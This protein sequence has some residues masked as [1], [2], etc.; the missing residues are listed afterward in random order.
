MTSRI[1][2]RQLWV[3]ENI[4]QLPLVY[5]A[6]QVPNRL[7]K[8][9]LTEAIESR[10]K[11]TIAQVTYALMC[12]LRIPHTS[13]II[14]LLGVGLSESNFEEM[15]KWVARELPTVVAGSVQDSFQILERRFR[16][17]VDQFPEV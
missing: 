2:K 13:T 17:V 15:S 3:D 14:G 9:L 11:K 7:F 16:Q 8:L 12:R 5:S 4:R 1:E 6:Q 10:N